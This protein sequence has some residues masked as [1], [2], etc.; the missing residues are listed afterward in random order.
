MKRTPL[1]LA[2]RAIG[3]LYARL[4]RLECKQ[5]CQKYCGPIAMSRVEWNRICN[6]LDD[7]P[8][9]GPDIVCPMLADGLCTVY[10]IRPVICRL[11][12][13][14]K[15]M[16]CQHGCVPERWLSDDEA[17]NLLAMVGQVGV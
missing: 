13:L 11:F 6:R 14:V 5:L 9:G 15:A 1:P 16:Q 2:I 3:R 7:S 10:D 8:R 4:P 17:R 12:R